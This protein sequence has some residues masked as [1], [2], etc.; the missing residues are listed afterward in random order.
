VKRRFSAR[1]RVQVAGDFFWAKGAIGTVSA[2]PDEVTAISGP[3]DEGLTRPEASAL[4]THTVYWVWFE[5]PQYDAD[6]DGPFRGVRLGR[7]PL[8]CWQ[9]EQTDPTLRGSVSASLEANHLST[10]GSST[11]TGL[12][13]TRSAC[14]TRPK[15]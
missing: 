9:Q 15:P 13:D 10:G 11:A 5:E 12:P 4:G 7:V 1:D 2:P 14:P 3:W 8:R 6:G